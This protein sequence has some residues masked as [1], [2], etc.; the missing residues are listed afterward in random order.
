[1]IRNKIKKTQNEINLVQERIGRN[2]LPALHNGSYSH[3]NN[4]S[5]RTL[6]HKPSYLTSQP[7]GY[8]DP[9]SYETTNRA[10]FRKYDSQFVLKR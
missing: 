9:I 3:Y 1:M 4:S 5:S 7:W 8:H 2:K 6:K 10:N